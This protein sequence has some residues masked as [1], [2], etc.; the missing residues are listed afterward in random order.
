[1]NEHNQILLK[2]LIRRYPALK[3]CERDL[4]NSIEILAEAYH[5][6][7]KILICGN[8]GSA[9][10]SEHIS[11][12]LLKS[13]MLKRACSEEDR[14]K[15]EMAG[16]DGLRLFNNLQK[17]IPA[18]PLS[19]LSS[20]MTAYM[21]DCDPELV[22]AQLVFALG[23]SGDVLISISTSGNS[24]NIYFASRTAKIL[25]MRTIALTG[26]SGGELN[27][28]CDICIKV[29]ETET[30]KVQELHLPVYHFLCAG[31]EAELFT[32]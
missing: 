29:P 6:G 28:I 23:K 12:E 9:S 24:K 8:G 30:F 7:K 25:G 13:F 16:E 21:N 22:Y 26:E 2:D 5:E 10:D 15:F 3:S 17:G 32:K 14:N 20:A 1:M 11:G 18:I 27:G 4:E 31:L 19:S